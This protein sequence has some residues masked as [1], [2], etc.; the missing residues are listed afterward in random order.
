MKTSIILA[1][2]SALTLTAAQITGELGDA[3]EVTNNPLFAN[4]FAEFTKA[5]AIRGAITRGLPAD[6]GP[7]A[8][9]LRDKLVPSDGDCGGT[10][11]TWARLNADNSHPATAKRQRHEVWQASMVKSTTSR[12]LSKRVS[13]TYTHHLSMGTL[14]TFG[15]RS[16]VIHSGGGS[17][18]ACANF[19]HGWEPAE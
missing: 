6:G 3:V 13:M 7:Y 14:R 1:A 5:S 4:V 2:L 15:N 19:T 17:R 12:R 11:A 10:A 9:H 8:Y 18:L 16:I